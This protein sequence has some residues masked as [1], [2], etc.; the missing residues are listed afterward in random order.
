MLNDNVKVVELFEEFRKND[1]F[2]ENLKEI[3]SILI[4]IY[5]EKDYMN[6]FKM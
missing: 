6:A 2:N 3:C 4:M 5:K 1:N